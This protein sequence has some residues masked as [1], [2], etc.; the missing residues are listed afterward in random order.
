MVV[1]A[2][3]LWGTCQVKEDM[4][5]ITRKGR[6]LSNIWPTSIHATVPHFFIVP[7]L[8]C[9]RYA[10]SKGI[11]PFLGAVRCYCLTTNQV[12]SEKES[13]TAL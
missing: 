1:A 10:K 13:Y 6:D 7:R 5:L 8:H 2:D 11:D 4:S 12:V 9:Q 3:T